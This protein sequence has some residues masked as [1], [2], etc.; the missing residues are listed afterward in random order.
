MIDEE[1]I[2][3][4]YN[5]WV[6]NNLYYIRDNKDSI[7]VMKEL[8]TNGFKDGYKKRGV[9]SAEEHLQK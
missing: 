3:K 4:S 8:Y 6:Y 2:E 5:E 1:D 9:I 7:K